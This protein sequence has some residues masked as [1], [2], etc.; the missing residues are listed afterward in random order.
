MEDH[1]RVPHRRR[2]GPGR[3]VLSQRQGRGRAD[4]ELPASRRSR[5]GAASHAELHRLRPQPETRGPGAEILEGHRSTLLAHLGN[6]SYRLGEEVP[7]DRMA[8]EFEGDAMFRES[9]E[10]MKRHLADTGQVELA[11]TPCRLGTPV[12]V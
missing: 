6:I 4:R 2:R 1:Q 7:F 11:S 5:T 9:F 12:D 8:G 3:Q 10:A